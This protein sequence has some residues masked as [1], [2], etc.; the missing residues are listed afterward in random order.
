MRFYLTTPI[1]YVNSTPH[2]GHAY[3]TAIGDMIVRYHRQRGDET[4]YLTGV[5]EHATKV[6]RVA[7]EQGLEAQEYADRI[8]VPWRE[9]PKRLNASTDFFIRTSDEGH[10]RFVQDFLQRMHDNGDV[11]QDVYA[12][13]YCVGCEAFKNED[14]LTADGL[15]P[16]HLVKPEWIEETNYFFRLS[17]YQERLL[18]LYDERPEL[19][20]PLFRFNEARSFIAGG[21]RDFSISRAGQPWGVP[22]PWDESQVAYVWADALINYLS[23][24]TYAREG[25]D[26]RDAFWPVVHHVLAKDILRFHC[27]YWPAMLLSAGYEPPQQLFVHGYLELG[28]RKISKSLGNVVEPLELIDVYGADALRFWMARAVSFGQDGSASVD[29]VR[30]RYE[31][32]LANDLG[33]LL[34]RTTAMIARYRGGRLVRGAAEAPLDLAALATEVSARFD[35]FDVT[36]ALETVWQGVRRLNQYVGAEA[37]WQL[38]KDEAQAD[39]LDGVLYNLVDGLTGLAV[40]LAPFLPETAPKILAALEQPGDVAWDRIRNGIAAEVEAIAAADPLFPRIEL[41]TAAA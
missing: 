12:G 36:G 1:Y 18:A 16:D 27:V 30:E 38:A 40:A 4:F 41:P 23:A 9:L 28:G 22:L 26:L 33:N 11:Y 31:T 13:W 7:Q 15:C 25:E 5:D 19:V 35:R 3:T 39:R 29:G 37:P 24:L 6:W 34:S 8:A 17:A 2:I 20:R 32:E 14:E 21:L 10:E